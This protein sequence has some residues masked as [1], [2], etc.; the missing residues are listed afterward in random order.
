MNHTWQQATGLAAVAWAIV[1]WSA[2]LIYAIVRLGAITFEGL[3]AGLTPLQQLLLGANAIFMAYAEGYRGFQRRFSPRAAARVLY[4]RR[5]ADLRLLLLAPCFCVGYFA[6]TP[7][8]LRLTWIGTVLI[9]GLI[10]IVHQLAQPWRG[11]VDAGVVVGLTWGLWSFWQLC[12]R[13]LRTGEFP[14]SPEV[15]SQPAPAPAAATH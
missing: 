8:I 11:I 4:L 15:P 10:L 1:G 9:V 13:A 5:H 3:S 7:R 14:V 6:A 12:W 2:V